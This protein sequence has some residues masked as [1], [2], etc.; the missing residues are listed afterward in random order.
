MGK[1]GSASR[2]LRMTRQREL[3]LNAVSSTRSHPTADEVYRQVRRRLPHISLGTVYRNLEV[4]AE[5]GLLRRLDLA[6]AQRRY[7]GETSGHYHVRCL[8]CGRVSDVAMKRPAALERRARAGTDYEI[9]GHRLEFVGLCPQCA[10][11]RR[12]RHRESG[13][14]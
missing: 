14:P 8:E 13:E 9:V 4:L 10:Q 5:A 2:K 3:I 12:A 11:A 1:R 6:G 7:D